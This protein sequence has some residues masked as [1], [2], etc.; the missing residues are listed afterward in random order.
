MKEKSVRY[1]CPAH[2][3]STH[4]L[5]RAS[6]TTRACRSFSSSSETAAKPYAYFM[7]PRATFEN[8]MA[9]PSKGAYVNR[10]IKP[11]YPGEKLDARRRKSS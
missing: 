10:R 4:L 5:S 1:I 3:K 9:A 6:N 11:K 8:L 7:V 2:K